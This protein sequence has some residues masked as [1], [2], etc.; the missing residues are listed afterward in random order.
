[1]ADF[2][3]TEYRAPGPVA[4]AYI[5]DPGRIVF[6]TGPQGSGKTHASIYKLVK[7]HHE[8]G[9]LCKDGWIRSR[10]VVVRER[11][12]VMETTTLQSWHKWFAKNYPGST[13]EGGGDRPA[14]QIL[15]WETARHG[16]RVKS[17]LIV[18]FK[19]LGD[20]SLEE[21]FKGWEGNQV[22][23][24]E[25]DQLDER[26][27]PFIYGRTGRYPSADLIADI[28]RDRPAFR[29]GFGDFNP[30][31]VQH[32]LYKQLVKERKF[33]LHRQP[34]G[35]SPEAEN[36]MN[37][38][39]GR[40]Y[41]EEQAAVMDE[42]DLRRLVH[43]EFGFTRDGLPVYHR[44]FRESLHVAREPLKVI[45]Q[46]PVHGGFDG[47]MGMTPA[48][49]FFQVTPAGQVRVLAECFDGHMGS[50]RFAE[51]VHRVRSERFGSCP[52]GMFGH[53]PAAVYGADKE[54]GELSWV[55]TMQVATGLPLTAAP[56]QEPGLRHDAVRVHF[57]RVLETGER[58]LI[59]CPSCEM[60]VAACVAYYRF[61]K[62]ND[63]S[64]EE[65]V[66]KNRYS[67]LMEALEYG[68]LTLYGRAGVMEAFT[69]PGLGRG[70]AAAPVRLK[71]DFR[72]FA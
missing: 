30:T 61:A 18:E 28:E 64:I 53:D 24:N 65:R 3:L 63:G 52:S 49:V 69:H 5:H 58:G 34:S 46:L 45:P 50:G 27:L 37:L 16:Q 41:Y 55:D 67:H 15:R 14:T 42:L 44:E 70:R 11:Q 59:I 32:W 13:W 51:L 20:N 68:L 35:L 1:M 26:T 57:N 33:P 23:G 12:R 43:G 60:I 47:G 19:G 6:I 39:G 36:L 21:N 40:A 56:S 17:E 2:T 38:Q 8:R 66:E 31:D 22:W 4:A 48:G 72:V 71:S 9:F 7:N 54:G 10:A 29:A 25:C 62:R